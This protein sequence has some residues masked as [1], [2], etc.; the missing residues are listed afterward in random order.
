MKK[1]STET[2]VKNAP[3]MAEQPKKKYHRK[4]EEEKQAASQKARAK[5]ELRAKREK[6]MRELA[7]RPDIQEPEAKTAKEAIKA[8]IDA[9]MAGKGSRKNVDTRDIE[10]KELNELT[11]KELDQ[12]VRRRAVRMANR[13]IENKAEE[14][15]K[16]IKDLRSGNIAPGGREYLKFSSQELIALFGG[17]FTLNYAFTIKDEQVLD[18]HGRPQETDYWICSRDYTDVP[19]K[20]WP[21]MNLPIKRQFG[22]EV[23]GYAIV[24]P[25]SAF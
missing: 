8:A 19:R 15:E 12:V 21:L 25:A 1:N 6:K 2:E 11:K 13:M 24:A 22:K 3:E 9:G 4:T 7:E 16:K 10:D 17:W 23:Y 20:E 5:R 14:L 18:K